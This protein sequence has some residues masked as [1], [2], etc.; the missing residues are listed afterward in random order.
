MSFS[1]FN[2]LMSCSVFRFSDSIFLR[3]IQNYIVPL[4]IWDELLAREGMNDFPKPLFVYFWRKGEVAK[5]E[6]LDV[7]KKTINYVV[8]VRRGLAS[9]RAGLR[10]IMQSILL[11]GLWVLEGTEDMLVIKN[12]KHIFERQLFESKYITF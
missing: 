3:S 10:V 7:T 2:L 9:S 11:N 5:Q 6:K 4:A 8:L 1:S 12:W